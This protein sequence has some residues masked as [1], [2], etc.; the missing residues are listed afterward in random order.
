MTLSLTQKIILTIISVFLITIG[1]SLFAHALSIAFI[2]VLIVAG[3]FVA[4]EIYRR[5]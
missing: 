4:Y 1:L 3:V 2:S 5:D